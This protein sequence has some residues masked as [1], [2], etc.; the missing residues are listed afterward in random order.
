MLGTRIAE[1]R[2]RAGLSQATLA[3]RLNI[4]PSA[5]GM[6]EQ[7][8]RMP[9]AS[10]LVALANELGVT[11]GTLLLPSPFITDPYSAP[12][13]QLRYSHALID[14]I[15]QTRHPYPFTK[16]ELITLCIALFLDS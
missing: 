5:L 3:N 13:K 4:S 10:T 7:G 12:I 8:R 9:S 11:T 2:H 1:L 14:T 16:Q 6:Y 15:L